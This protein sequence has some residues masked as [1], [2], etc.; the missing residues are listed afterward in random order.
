MGMV[1]QKGKFSDEQALELRSCRM[2]TVGNFLYGF[3]GEQQAAAH[4]P[5]GQDEG[6]GEA[7]AWQD[8]DSGEMVAET[9]GWRGEAETPGDM[10]AAKPAA[11]WLQSME[12][13]FVEEEKEQAR[14][15]MVVTVLLSLTRLTEEGKLGINITWK[16]GEVVVQEPK[17]THIHDLH[18]LQ[19]GDKIVGVR[20]EWPDSLKAFQQMVG[21][22]PDLPIP[23]M[24]K[25]VQASDKAPD[26]GGE[27]EVSM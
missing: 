26:E 23:I 2:E 9:S 5:A 7:V 24:V 12:E 18:G 1:N 11:P 25:R 22:P 14:E 4:D 27:C 15:P 10:L 16:N 17:A 13:M 3:F 8:A 20:D 19:V 21:D 6:P